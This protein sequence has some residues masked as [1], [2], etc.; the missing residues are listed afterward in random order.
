MYKVPKCELASSPF[1]VGTP[2]D[3]ITRRPEKTHYYYVRGQTQC[4]VHCAT[5]AKALV[6]KP[7]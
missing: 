4:T 6:I 1:P 2:L 5:C 7:P 3:H